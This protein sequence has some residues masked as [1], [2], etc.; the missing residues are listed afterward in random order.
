MTGTIWV[1]YR[2]QMSPVA[3]TAVCWGVLTR[4][5]GR[6]RSARLAMVIAHLNDGAQKWTA[7]DVRWMERERGD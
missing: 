7:V 3:A 2:D 6:V 4:S 1:A 5:T